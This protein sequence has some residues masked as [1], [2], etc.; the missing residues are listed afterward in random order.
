MRSP[1]RTSRSPAR[2]EKQ[3]QRPKST[4]RDSSLEERK[5]R[6]NTTPPR[7]DKKNFSPRSSRDSS[8]L[9]YSPARRNPERYRD[10]LESANNKPKLEKEKRKEMDDIRK[11]QKK[12]SKRLQDEQDRDKRREG[13]SESKRDKNPLKPRVHLQS[14]S[15][16]DENSDTAAE[17]NTEKILEE[18]QESKRERE[19]K[20]LKMLE[21]LKTGIAAKAKEKI[22][23]IEKMANSSTAASTSAVGVGSGDVSDQ[24]YAPKRGIRNSLNDFLAANNKAPAVVATSAQN[25]QNSPPGAIYPQTLE[26]ITREQK[27]QNQTK[28]SEVESER[29]TDIETQAD[30]KKSPM[31]ANG[32][33][34]ASPK[35]SPRPPPYQSGGDRERKRDQYHYHRERDAK[36]CRDIKPRETTTIL[37]NS[38]NKERFNERRQRT[39]PSAYTAGGGGARRP[40]NLNI[41]PPPHHNHRQPRMN[42]NIGGMGAGGLH[43]HHLNHH[44]NPN[45]PFS[46]PTANNSLNLNSNNSINLSFNRPSR[47]NTTP[48]ITATQFN[49]QMLS[50][51]SNSILVNRR[52]HRTALTLGLSSTPCT[53]FSN[54]N[55]LLTKANLNNA[56]T[57][58]L[59]GHLHN[60][61]HQHHHHHHHHHHSNLSS[62]NAQITDR[63]LM[64]A[65]IAAQR[66]NLGLNST[67]ATSVANNLTMLQQQANAKPKI[68]IKPFKINDSQPLVAALADSS[69]VD[70]IVSKVSTATV[71]A[72]ESA[73]RRSRSRSR[74]SRSRT[75][76]DDGNDGGERSDRGAGGGHG[77]SKSHSRS[78]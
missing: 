44:N 54:T 48:L 53:N 61:H 65:S 26:E 75:R 4:E 14:Q 23:T 43:H 2:I 9:S 78:S 69:L 64:A 3:Q 40:N 58:H 41:H 68:V 36:D 51:Q 59:H 77:R 21:Q 33:A 10:I 66:H 19:L 49:N 38:N 24:T 37:N 42:G 30:C 1:V 35:V 76:K 12:S 13:G 29:T 46:N 20:D 73:A 52:D 70:A 28:V 18:F 34:N 15:D 47:I 16:E 25:V 5:K 57:H 6:D 72:A 55:L 62:N 7:L 74:R 71:A 56:T 45:S 27:S 8:E 22:K 50:K 67:T 63:I 39:S 17:R 32:H 11:D 60:Q 31:A